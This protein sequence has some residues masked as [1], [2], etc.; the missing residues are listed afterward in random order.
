M[1]QPTIVCGLIKV[2]SKAWAVLTI[3][4]IQASEIGF[5][6]CSG[7]NQASESELS[8]PTSFE[9]GMGQFLI[10]YKPEWHACYKKTS[11]MFYGILLA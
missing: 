5:S 4:D 11:I 7:D 3:A 1:K 2:D 8:R 10:D 6:R 9:G